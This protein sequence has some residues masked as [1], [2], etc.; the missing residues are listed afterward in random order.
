MQQ[1]EIATSPT[2]PLSWRRDA[3]RILEGETIYLRERLRV[4]AEEAVRAAG[5]SRVTPE[6]V[7]SA[8]RPPGQGARMG[9][10]EPIPEPA[11]P[12]SFGAYRVL[13]PAAP[14]A[15]CTLASETLMES[16]AEQRPPGVA[17]VGRALTENFG[18]EK[19]ALNVVA[20]RNLR[21]LVLCGTESRHRVGETLMA[22][23]ARGTDGD[24]RVIGATSP[25]PLV[26]SLA[27]DAVRIFQQKLTLVDLRGEDAPEV[28]LEAAGRA[29]H[30]AT[31]WSEGWCPDVP[32]I[33]L[34]AGP[35][36]MGSSGSRF[37]PDPTGLFLIGIGP[38]GR[39]IH[40]EHYD[41]EGHFDRRTVGDSAAGIAGVL[42]AEGL[43][44]DLGHA[45]YVGR[46]LQKAETALRL[47]VAYE[48]DRELVV[49]RSIV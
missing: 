19:L 46:E 18:V 7:E 43:L 5:R 23:H 40:V 1:E 4:R 39:T 49:G 31:P 25:M 32:T 15:I 22:L 20:N 8:R 33:R 30:G 6:D 47:G 24:G 28:I 16:L 3:T 14:V 27:P 37:T 45:A 38:S 17:I 2:G 34:G 44:G 9:G 26:R 36:T 29:G 12:I 13:D 21:V 35:A 42:V 48:Q 10:G 11:W 41:R